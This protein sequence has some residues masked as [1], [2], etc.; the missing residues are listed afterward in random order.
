MDVPGE[1]RS[2]S[3]S[4]LPARPAAPLSLVRPCYRAQR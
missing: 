4:L 2:S 3:E 1:W